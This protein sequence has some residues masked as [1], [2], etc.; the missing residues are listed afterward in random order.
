MAKTRV[1]TVFLLCATAVWFGWLSFDHNA[2]SSNSR[3]HWVD[4]FVPSSRMDDYA[5]ALIRIPHYLFYENPYIWQSLNAAANAGILLLIA[6][7]IGLTPL[8]SLGAA[9][10]IAIS[11]NLLV[12]ANTGEDLLFNF[13]LIALVLLSLTFQKPVWIGVCLALATLGRPQF[14]LLVPC[15]LAGE[16]L[17]DIRHHRSLRAIRWPYL[18]SIAV[19]V[20]VLISASQMLF[21]VIGDRYLFVDGRIMTFSANWQISSIEVDGFLI[22]AFSGTYLWHFLWIFP[23]PVLLGALAS[24]WFVPRLDRRVQALVHTSAFGIVALLLLSEAIPLLYFNV[25]YLTYLLP[26]LLV[27]AWSLIA[28]VD[29]HKSWASGSPRVRVLLTVCMLLSPIVIPSGALD[30]RRIR[31]ER[32]EYEL[33]EVRNELRTAAAESEQV[34]LVEYARGRRNFVAYVLRDDVR[35]IVPFDPEALPA[36]SLVIGL[37]DSELLTDEFRST[38]SEVVSTKHYVA[39]QTDG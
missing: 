16:V 37:R 21:T 39:L 34:L 23:A 33:L 11:G 24:L 10:A 2:F 38:A 9:S 32:V 14:M 19:T 13:G 25:R 36:R 30:G 6:R 18:V 3:I 29:K 20:G 4:Y 26:F 28:S 7:R 5:Y 27:M 22:D 15:V 17:T 8:A 12:F 35:S 1:F 31:A